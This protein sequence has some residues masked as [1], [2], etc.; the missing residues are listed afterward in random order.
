MA[1]DLPIQT[2]SDRELERAA[3]TA[4]L[5][6]FPGVPGGE[7]KVS[8]LEARFTNR[9]HPAAMIST[10]AGTFLLTAERVSPAVAEAVAVAEAWKEVRPRT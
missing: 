1:S 9:G 6:D 2:S 10:P 5:F 7:V 4:L 3:L 8:V